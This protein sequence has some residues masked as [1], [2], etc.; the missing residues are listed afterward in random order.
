M[1]HE[2]ASER[3]IFQLMSTRADGDEHTFYGRFHTCSQ[4]TDGRWRICVDYDTGER[5]AT[6]DEEFHAAIDVH[7]V[8]AFKE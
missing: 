5:S 3:G 1:A 2:V 7:D 6:L 4:R 8:D